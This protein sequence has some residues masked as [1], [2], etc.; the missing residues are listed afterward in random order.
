MINIPSPCQRRH[1]FHH[2]YGGRAEA[3]PLFRKSLV[4]Q[5]LG[6][7]L[8]ACAGSTTGSWQEISGITN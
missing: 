7:T 3:P 5:F 1:H 8:P 6:R 2:L 4:F